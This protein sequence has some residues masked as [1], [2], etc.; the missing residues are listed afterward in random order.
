MKNNAKSVW[1]LEKIERKRGKIDRKYEKYIEKWKK[2]T[3]WKTHFFENYNFSRSHYSNPFE[4]GVQNF[5][6]WIFNSESTIFANCIKIRVFFSLYL[7]TSVSS[8]HG[9][10][11][12]FASKFFEGSFEPKGNT[13]RGFLDENAHFEQISGTLLHICT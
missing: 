8:R 2:K 3:I 12:F 4:V 9:L 13:L 10:K 1:K 5:M 6:W 7:I 11:L